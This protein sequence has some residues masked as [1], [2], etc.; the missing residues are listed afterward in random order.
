[1]NSAPDFRRRY[2]RIFIFWLLFMAMTASDV[3]HAGPAKFPVPDWLTTTQ[4][5][6]E[7]I[8][9]GLPSQVQY[10][11]S[12]NSIPELLVFYR[13][14]WQDKLSES[15]IYKE[16]QAAPWQI[17]SKFDGRYLYTVQ[18]RSKNPWAI[19]GYLAIAD[20]KAAKKKPK[21]KPAVPQMSGSTVM[22]DS[23]SSDSG[24]L[25]RTL[26][27]INSYSAESNGSFYRNYYSSRGWTKVMDTQS[28]NTFVLTFKKNSKDAHLVINPTGN[29]TQIVMNIT[30][31]I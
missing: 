4:I 6:D 22:S 19:T 5:A 29:T 16:T 30:E 10:F 13:N 25:A 12:D 20:L 24:T 8:I 3:A 31:Q 23:S 27:L 11:E 21:K 14:N 18:V 17:I 26:M 7:M 1:M 28:E 15:Q 9:N 2:Y